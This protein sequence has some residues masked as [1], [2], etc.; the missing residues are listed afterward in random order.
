MAYNL[1]SSPSSPKGG[2]RR[3]SSVGFMQNTATTFD[4]NGQD[5]PMLPE[6]KMPTVSS[7]LKHFLQ[8]ASL[9]ETRSRKSLEDILSQNAP[10]SKQFRDLY[11]KESMKINSRQLVLLEKEMIT[12]AKQR[13]FEMLNVI[14]KLR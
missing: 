11:F 2:F 3:M 9:G 13:H 7:G 1:A 10:V 12:A 14:S 8:M 5:G 4:E 6:D